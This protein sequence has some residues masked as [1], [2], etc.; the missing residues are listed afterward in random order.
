MVNREWRNGFVQQCDDAECDV[1]AY[2]RR[3]AGG[4]ALDDYGERAVSAFYGECDDYDQSIAHDGEC[5]G[6]SEDTDLDAVGD[7]GGECA[8]CRRRRVVNRAWAV[9]VVV[10]V[11]Q[12][13]ESGGDVYASGRSGLLHFALDDQQCA[14]YGFE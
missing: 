9:G 3:G 5:G 2:G 12:H 4:L 1:Y 10:A 14:V 8:E 7:A 13:D 6:G 11:Q